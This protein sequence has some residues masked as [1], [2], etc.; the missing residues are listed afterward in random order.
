MHYGQNLIYFR[1][2]FMAVEK[3]LHFKTVGWNILQ[4]FNNFSL[5][6]KLLVD[7]FLNVGMSMDKSWVLC[8]S[9]YY[10]LYILFSILCK[11]YY[12]SWT[13]S[14]WSLVVLFYEISYINVCCV[15]VCNCFIFLVEYFLYQSLIF[16]FLP[17]QIGIQQLLLLF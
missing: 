12:Y 9:L 7:F 17:C 5:S 14:S 11:I 6:L 10:I 16:Q 3:N 13:C 2:Y 8:Q 1:E 15:Y 4:V